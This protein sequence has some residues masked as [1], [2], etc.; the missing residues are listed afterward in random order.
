MWLV[1]FGLSKKKKDGSEEDLWI[2]RLQVVLE[3]PWCRLHGRVDVANMVSPILICLESVPAYVVKTTVTFSVG[4]SCPFPSL[5]LVNAFLPLREERKL[6][7][8]LGTLKE[9]FSFNSA[10][11]LCH[12]KDEKKCN[13][14]AQNK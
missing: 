9:F 11:M 6:W 10:S 13:S 5:F 3:I 8:H 12:Q 2:F 7:G 14:Y 1:L 4:A